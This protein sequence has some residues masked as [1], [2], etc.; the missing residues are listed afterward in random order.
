MFA[1]R[2]SKKINSTLV[3]KYL[4]QGLTRLLAIYD[5][6][7]TLLMRFTYA[8]SRLPVTMQ[9]GGATYYLACDQVGSLRIVT[10]AAGTV[11]KTMDYDSF[12][13][14][15]QDSNPTFDMPFGFAGGL[16]DPDTGL[17]RFGF[18]EYSPEIGRWTAKD[19]ILFLGGSSDLY[20]YCISDPINFIDSIGLD[21]TPNDNGGYWQYSQ[22]TGEISHVDADGTTT[23]HGQGYSGHGGGVNEPSVQRS[24]NFGPIP[25]GWWYIGPAYTHPTKGPITMSLTSTVET[26]AYGRNLFLIH[27]D[28]ACL[29]QSASEGC[30]IFGPNIRNMVSNSPHRYLKVVR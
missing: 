24:S 9:S 5:A 19:P 2:N 30:V 25:R 8:D 11:I 17:V 14:I 13:N 1:L 16:H 3:E 23:N 20:G 7:N 15:I 28:N 18:R 10:D 27:G 6:D 29:C 12:G 21:N 26:D 22:S 4:W